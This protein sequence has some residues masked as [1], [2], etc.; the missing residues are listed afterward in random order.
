MATWQSQA[1]M[2]QL[3]MP[4]PIP[5]WVLQRFDELLWALWAAFANKRRRLRCRRGRHGRLRQRRLRQRRLR[6]RR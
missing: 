3:Q 5:Q 6:Q 1:P 4:Q 2:M